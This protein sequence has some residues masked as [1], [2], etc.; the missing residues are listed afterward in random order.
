VPPLTDRPAVV[1]ADPRR[2]YSLQR[3][4]WSD[5]LWR[6]LARDRRAHKERMSRRAWCAIVYSG[7]LTVKPFTGAA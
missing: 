6:Q 3:R 2:L 1:W 5:R 7:R 4:R